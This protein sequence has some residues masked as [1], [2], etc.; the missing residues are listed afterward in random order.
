MK[1]AKKTD[2]ARDAE[3][4]SR[5]PRFFD[6]KSLPLRQRT[7][8]RQRLFEAFGQGLGYAEAAE[9][10]NLRPV[11]VRQIFKRF[12]RDGESAVHEKPHGSPEHVKPFLSP[13]EM[14]ALEAALAAGGPREAGVEG[15]ALWSV[16]AVME[17]GRQ[18]CGKDLPA[19]AALSALQRL[20]YSK[21]SPLPET[22]KVIRDWKKEN[23]RE[24]R[25][26]A[27]G[28]GAIMHW[29]GEMIASPRSA[30]IRNRPEQ[31]ALPEAA[32][33]CVGIFA[34]QQNNGATYFLPLRERMTPEW[35]KSFVEGLM[36]DVGKP[37]F[38]IV[39][40]RPAYRTGVM[41]E[42]GREQ[43]HAGKLWMRYCPKLQRPRL[44][45][46]EPARKRLEIDFDELFG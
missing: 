14:D 9:K 38:L 41:E 44:P 32:V 17:W 28:K 45:G 33:P 10:F 27:L 42:W 4:A 15:V 2:A 7:V 21:E 18:R 16:R 25:N 29:C 46:Q 26:M 24:F 40:D 30:R 23:F 36:A 13:A 12:Q 39:E 31:S 35:F 3:Q 22:R 8:V 11:T 37:L 34:A 20:G 43:R 5:P 1:K 19:R 6:L